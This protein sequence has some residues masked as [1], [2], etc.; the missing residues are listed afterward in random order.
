MAGLKFILLKCCAANNQP[1]WRDAAACNSD[2]LET[3]RDAS[4]TNAY[5]QSP[6][7]LTHFADAAAHFGDGDFFDQSAASRL[8]IRSFGPA[9]R[10]GKAVLRKSH[11]I[12][13]VPISPAPLAV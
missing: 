8:S 7:H 5:N 1:G 9:G 12:L 13:G 11:R 6:N 10:S 3:R 2:I 4:P